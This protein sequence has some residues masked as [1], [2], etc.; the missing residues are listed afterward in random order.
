MIICF[1]SV[2]L[3]WVGNSKCRGNMHNIKVLIS[4]KSGIIGYIAFKRHRSNNTI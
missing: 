2:I 4:I 1:P 3:K